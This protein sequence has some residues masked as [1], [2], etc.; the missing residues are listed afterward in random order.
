MKDVTFYA[1]RFIDG[2]CLSFDDL[3]EYQDFCDS[4]DMKKVE[5][6]FVNESLE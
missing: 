4:V 3:K 2:S 1:V 5:Y 6:V